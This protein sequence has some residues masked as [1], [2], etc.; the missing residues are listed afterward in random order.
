M[1]AVPQNLADAQRAIPE[2]FLPEEMSGELVEAEH[3]VRYAWAASLAAGR[4]VLDA[5]T[6]AGYGTGML[7]GAGAT[8]TVGID[9]AETVVEAARDAYGDVAEFTAADI[10]SLPFDDDSFDLVVCFEVI[11]HVDR[12]DDALAE[13]A[14]VLAPG[15]ILAVSS[16]NR[17][18]SV[19]GNPHHVHEYTPDELDAA[20][21]R[22]FAH[23]ALWHQQNVL[24]SVLLAADHA[25]GEPGVVEGLQVASTAALRAD[26]QL[27][28]IALASD[29]PLP[30][31]QPL[32][33]ATGLVEV[34]H[35][36]EE[37]ARQHEL[38][39][40]QAAFLADLQRQADELGALRTQLIE[41]ELVVADLTN[42][43]AEIVTLRRELDDTQSRRQELEDHYTE[44]R[45]RAEHLENVL[46]QMRSSLSWKLTGPLR[47]AKRLRG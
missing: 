26:A 37:F 38:L 41:S 42:V 18:R 6:G 35:W 9:V 24:G 40:R 31:P 28:S 21:A 14:R 12:Q 10:R 45:N 33:V 5:G 11:E 8:R 43:R 22:Q 27:Y 39:E 7:A 29:A 15:G 2:R 32:A 20:V 46:A 30:N 1:E 3:L 16:P 19:P 13:F 4:R 23:R 44:A 25:G 17:D 47:K 34:R 36:V